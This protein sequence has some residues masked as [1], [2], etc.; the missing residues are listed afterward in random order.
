M[1]DY[2]FLYFCYFIYSD[3][4]VV[5]FDIEQNMNKLLTSQYE[6]NM[7]YCSSLVVF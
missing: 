5:K 4:T 6:T 1:N 7:L 2:I 3:K